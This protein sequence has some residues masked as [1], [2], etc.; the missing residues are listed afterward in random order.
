MIVTNCHCFMTV[1]NKFRK[2]IHTAFIIIPM[3]LLMC[4]TVIIRNYGF[5]EGWI[6]QYIKTWLVMFPIAYCA[7]LIIFPVANKLTR[8]LKFID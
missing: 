6:L 3:T 8:K 1:K 4:I 7:A 5:Q 2:Y